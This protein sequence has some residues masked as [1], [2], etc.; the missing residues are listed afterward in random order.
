M[1]FDQEV[2]EDKSALGEK[3]TATNKLKLA[4]KL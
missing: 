4:I 1:H 2:A 3:N